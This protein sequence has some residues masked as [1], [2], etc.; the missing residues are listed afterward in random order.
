MPVLYDQ[1]TQCLGSLKTI[2]VSMT[3]MNDT[4]II[5]GKRIWIV[6]DRMHPQHSTCELLHMHS[7]FPETECSSIS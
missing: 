4:P 5:P 1:V 6:H 2:L 7:F 3:T